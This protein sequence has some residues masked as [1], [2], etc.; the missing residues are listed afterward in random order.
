MRGEPDAVMTTV[1]VGAARTLRLLAVIGALAAGP[2]ALAQTPPPSPKPAP[3]SLPWLLRPAAAATVARVDETLAF[4]EDPASRTSGATYLTGFTGSHK[5]GARLAAVF[6][7]TWVHNAPPSGGRDPAG[8]AFSNPLFG[9]NYVHPLS[10]AWRWTGFFATTLPFG[11]G[12]GDHPDPGAAAAMNAAIPA[13]SGMDNALFA[14]NYWTVIGGVGLARV[15]SGLTAQAELTLLQLTRVRGPESQDKSRTNLTAG[16]HLGHFFSPRLS[17][18]GELRMQ[19]WMSDSAPVRSNP[20]AREQLTF[21]IGPRLHFKVGRRF[22]LRPG[23]S[24]TRAL[25]EPMSAKSYDILLI[26]APVTF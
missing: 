24:Y 6:R 26:D 20:T 25:D 19:R 22:W 16:L 21:G 15:S 9:L 8:S 12:G 23:L 11:S 3:Y 18:G 14:V 4:V 13:R 1:H 5:L 17:V 10:R 7:E 2:A